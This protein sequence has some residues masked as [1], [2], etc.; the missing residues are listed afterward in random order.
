[1]KKCLVRG[2][3]ANDHLIDTVEDSALP[4]LVVKLHFGVPLSRRLE[5]LLFDCLQ[6]VVTD[7]LVVFDQ[8]I[9]F[10]YAV[11]L[12]V[13]AELRDVHYLMIVKVDRADDAGVLDG[14]YLL[15][16]VAGLLE[17]SAFCVFELLNLFVTFFDVF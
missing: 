15:F 9:D 7:V 10:L 6:V 4:I 8:G 3:G 2:K 16:D 14:L 1:M 17:D 5:R 13:V 11:I 12:E